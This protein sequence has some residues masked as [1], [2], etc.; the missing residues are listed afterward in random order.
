[1]NQS[2][3]PSSKKS[4]QK[5]AKTSKAGTD[6]SLKCKFCF[7]IFEGQPEFFQHVINSHPKMLEQRLNQPNTTV[8]TT[9]TSTTNTKPIANITSGKTASNRVANSNG[10]SNHS[11]SSVS[12][13]SAND[14]K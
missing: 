1:V 2:V 14:K 7:Q 4:P 13:G 9:N 6:V 5:T 12:N 8:P 10:N 11:N 3:Q